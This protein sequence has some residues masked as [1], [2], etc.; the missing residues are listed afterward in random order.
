MTTEIKFEYNTSSSWT[1][2]VKMNLLYLM[3]TFEYL[4]D[5]LKARGVL[6]L[7]EILDTL[8]M[9]VMAEDYGIVWIGCDELKVDIVQDSSGVNKFNI[10]LV[11]E[12]NR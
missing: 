8:G 11:K 3:H 4:S 6:S 7:A 9:R 2:D 1:K 5:K 12:S 10:T